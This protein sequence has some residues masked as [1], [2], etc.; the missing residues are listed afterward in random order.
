MTAEEHSIIG[1]LGAAVSE[2][3]TGCYPV[4]VKRVGLPDCFAETGSYDQILDRYGLVNSPYHRSC[5]KCAAH[6]K[7]REGKRMKAGLVIC[8]PDVRY[9]PLAL[10]QRNL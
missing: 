2:V 8:G 7:V 10:T 6:E 4:P 5:A 9:G 3:V 1:G